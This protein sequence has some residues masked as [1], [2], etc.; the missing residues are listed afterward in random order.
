MAVASNTGGIFDLFPK[1]VKDYLK[2]EQLEDTLDLT[3]MSLRLARD[4]TFINAFDKSKNMTEALRAKIQKYKKQK[5]NFL[6]TIQGSTGSGKS[7]TMLSLAH[8]ISGEEGFPID[9]IF[10]RIGDAIRSFDQLEPGETILIDERTREWGA[11]SQRIASEWANFTE[12]IRKFQIN[13]LNSTPREMLDVLYTNRFETL[14]CQ[15]DYVREVARVAI[16]DNKKNTLGWI[17][18]RHPKHT[19]GADFVKEYEDRKDRFLFD[20]MKHSDKGRI[21]TLADEFMECDEYKLLLERFPSGPKYPMIFEAV[22]QK[23]PHLQRNQEVAEIA[24]KVEYVQIMELGL[25]SPD[26]RRQNRKSG[27]RGDD[28]G[29]PSLESF[30]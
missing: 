3:E 15:I 26:E 6:A 9:N 1:E 13:I 30:F 22:D 14:P 19:V 17:A 18:V 16:Q 7:Y 24:R 5:R 23:Y 12:V 10:F 27:G 29:Q 20:I 25:Q 2:M 4:P 8:L 28:P 11:G 21:R